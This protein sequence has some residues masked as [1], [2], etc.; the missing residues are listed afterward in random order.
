MALYIVKIDKSGKMYLPKELREEVPIL[1]DQTIVIQPTKIDDNAGLVL[2]PDT[3]APQDIN[4]FA[5]MLSIGP[6][7][8][9]EAMVRGLQ[10]VVSRK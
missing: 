6:E 9:E 10:R 5:G 3:T 4:S 1:K 2:F 7:K 8:W